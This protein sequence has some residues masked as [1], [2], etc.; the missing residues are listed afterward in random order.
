MIK[1]D[2]VTSV[3]R[4]Y[5][6]NAIVPDAVMNANSVTPLMLASLYGS[7]DVAKWLLVRGAK[8]NARTVLKDPDKFPTVGDCTALHMACA[9]NH[10]DVARL[11][12]EH[13]ADLSQK[14]GNGNTA[15]ILACAKGQLETI[16]LLIE[17]GASINAP[18]SYHWTPL[19]VAADQDQSVLAEFL[20][21]QGA[22]V[23]AGG[24][25][26]PLMRASERGNESLVR[27]LIKQGASVNHTNLGGA[28]A[29]LDAAVEGHAEVV[30][31]LIQNGAKLDRQNEEG[32]TALAEAA[33]H[34]HCETVRIRRVVGAAPAASA[35]PA[36]CAE[37]LG[38]AR[39]VRCPRAFIEAA[40]A[41]GATL[42]LRCDRR[43]SHRIQVARDART[44]RAR[45]DRIR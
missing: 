15:F 33:A 19:S 26:T 4:L 42:A 1:V 45:A 2:D 9:R 25:R 16:K 29:L 22:D 38:G 23:N 24:G 18:N 21:T 40:A 37:Q 12:I 6:T 35:S 20:I 7:H 11:L 28:S 13:G 30:K 3:E 44:L 41:R 31:L 36:S 17:H 27:L 39:T 8:A 34:G 43:R 32:W 14:D 5:S 10:L